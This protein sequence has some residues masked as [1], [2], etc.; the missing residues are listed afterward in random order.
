MALQYKI[1]PVTPYEQNSTILWCDKTN[2][3]AI[4]DPGGDLDKILSAINELNV[5]LE[6][7]Y[8]THGHIDHAGGAGELSQKLSL[9]ISGPHKADLFW[10]EGLPSQS[11]MFGFPQAIKFIPNLWLEDGDTI[12]VGNEQ[13][14]VLHCPGHTPG[15]VV[16][17][18]PSSQLA[19]VGDVLFNGSVGRSDFPQGDHETL[20]HS[21]K[22]KLLP[23]GDKVSFIPGHGPNSTMGYEAKNNPFLQ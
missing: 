7:I 1:I 9:P 12:K 18:H 19:L 22:N 10:L 6:A 17:Y 15:H 8:L 23:L 20:I 16:F 13:L 4:V 14:A 5:T 3:A 21:I 11:Q 2:K